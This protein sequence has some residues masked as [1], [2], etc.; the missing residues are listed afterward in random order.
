MREISNRAG[1]LEGA[2]GKLSNL[3]MS[4][5]ELTVRYKV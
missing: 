3:G 5:Q 4:L 1:E 2:A